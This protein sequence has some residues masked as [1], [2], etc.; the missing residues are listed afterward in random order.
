MNRT[1][2]IYQSAREAH[3]M[4]QEAV[5]EKLFIS[6]DS[7]RAYETGRRR[8]PDDVVQDMVNLYQDK[9]LGYLHMRSSPLASCIPRVDIQGVQ[10]AAMR[11]VRL[12]GKFAR[13][14]RVDQLL[15][16]AED[17]KID[18]REK[19]VFREIMDELTQ[20]VESVLALNF[21][22]TGRT[23]TGDEYNKAG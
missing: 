22:G 6:V 18:E 1:R 12:I 13:A 10:Q 16:I 5:A 11:I 15:E 7:L 9:Y 19:P 8:P 20:I 4:T 14:G 23:L 17:G 3:G 21:A 2:N